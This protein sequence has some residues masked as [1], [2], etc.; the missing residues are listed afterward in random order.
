MRVQSWARLCVRM[1]RRFRLSPSPGAS[2][3]RSVCR[4]VYGR[5]ARGPMSPYSRKIERDLRGSAQMLHSGSKSY[6]IG[7]RFCCLV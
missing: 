4:G 6:V 7:V 2:S 5:L 3:S 1:S